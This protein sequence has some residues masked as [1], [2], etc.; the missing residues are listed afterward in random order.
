MRFVQVAGVLG[1]LAMVSLVGARPDKPEFLIA[2][3]SDL[4]FAMEEIAGQ[5]QLEH[6]EVAVKTIYGSSGHFLAQIQY[7]APFDIFCSADMA[8]PRKLVDSGLA[9]PGSEFLYAVGHLVVWVP[10]ASRLNL[11]RDGVKALLDPSVVHISIASPEHAPYGVAA[12]AAM[13]SLGVYDAVRAKLVYGDNVSQALQ[14]VQ[15]GSADIG[16]VSLSLAVS[17][18]AKGKGRYWEV[19]LSAYPKM[20][21]GGVITKWT[22]H[23][24][25][26]RAFRIFV[27]GDMSRG[28]FQS[29]GFSAPK[30]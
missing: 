9:L 29:Y 27:L 10:A 5:F 24:D 3:A 25:I 22:E 13:R 8:Y 2:A 1:V 12:V 19:P 18:M 14:Y 6:P 20:E 30:K 7:G 11:E 4:R 28:V 15:S 21:Q 17:P 26:A 23:E 16:I